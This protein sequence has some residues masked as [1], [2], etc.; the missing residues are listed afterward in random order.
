MHN[1]FEFLLKL[2]QL[3][4]DSCGS[5]AVW[6]IRFSG[7]I[8]PPLIWISFA[9]NW[10]YLTV[11]KVPRPRR[12]SQLNY[13]MFPVWCAPF[14][15]TLLGNNLKLGVLIKCKSFLEAISFEQHLHWLTIIP[16]RST[17]PSVFHSV[18]RTCICIYF[19]LSYLF[20]YLYLSFGF[21][22]LISFNNNHTIES[23]KNKTPSK[24]KWKWVKVV[25]RHNGCDTGDSQ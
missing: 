5:C 2:V 15:A 24:K 11:K 1:P 9:L 6:H 10:P 22:V 17:Y 12:Q 20:I 19:L 4:V 3:S 14:F 25:N 23:V 7:P 18:F 21:Y 8:M 16:R 13:L